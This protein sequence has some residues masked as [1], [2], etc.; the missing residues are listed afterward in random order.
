MHT[1]RLYNELERH[2]MRPVRFPVKVERTDNAFSFLQVEFLIRDLF[3][4]QRHKIVD[5]GDFAVLRMFPVEFATMCFKDSQVFD[6]I[7]LEVQ[8]L[9]QPNLKVQQ[10]SV[11]RYK[12][13]NYLLLPSSVRLCSFCWKGSAAR[14]TSLVMP[15]GSQVTFKHFLLS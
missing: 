2:T 1:Y 3:S 9:L 5:T 11:P 7:F 4:I 14:L 6:R 15:S 13:F 10:S 8:F 12:Y